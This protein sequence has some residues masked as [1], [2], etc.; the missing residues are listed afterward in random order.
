MATKDFEKLEEREEREKE[1]R[2]AHVLQ[3][4]RDITKNWNIDI[5]A[6]LEEYLHEVCILLVGICSSRLQ[7]PHLL[8][9]SLLGFLAVKPAISSRG[10]MKHFLSLLQVEQLTFSFDGGATQLNFAEA[11]L[12]IQGSACIYSRKV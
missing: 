4:I 6:E 7:S 8:L 11:A 5:A 12:L 3:P 10:R 1:N 2:F 9:L